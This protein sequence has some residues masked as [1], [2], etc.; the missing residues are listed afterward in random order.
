ME[1]NAATSKSTYR[2]E[3]E[4]RYQGSGLCISQYQSQLSLGQ[5]VVASF[6]KLGFQV[7]QT[8]LQKL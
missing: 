3:F 5:L 8:C 7:G 2:L 6:N 4:Y 1:H